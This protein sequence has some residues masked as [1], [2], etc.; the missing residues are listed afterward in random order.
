M[1]LQEEGE[2]AEAE[3]VGVTSIEK[4]SCI[5][6]ES[7]CA[8]LETI[9]QQGQLSG[10]FKCRRKPVQNGALL[11]GLQN[12]PLYPS[13]SRASPFL[14]KE[15]TTRTLSCGMKSRTAPFPSLSALKHRV[16]VPAAEN[17]AVTVSPEGPRLTAPKTKFG[18][19]APRTHTPE[20]E[21]PTATVPAG[22]LLTE[23]VVG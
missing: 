13:P 6:E 8:A 14:P 9:D 3:G 5:L 11:S 22:R 19:A 16:Y 17:V 7:R 4:Y 10:K 1:G 23:N 20:G 12:S 2:E 15:T 21:K 18:S